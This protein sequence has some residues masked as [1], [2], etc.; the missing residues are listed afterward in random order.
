M[1]TVQNTYSINITQDELA[2][3]LSNFIIFLKK[4][5]ITFEDNDLEF[6]VPMAVEYLH[7]AFGLDGNPFQLVIKVA[8]RLEKEYDVA[9]RH[10]DG[11]WDK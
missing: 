2:T 6:D 10:G 3:L 1:H 4:D 5:E 8:D 9:C 11:D 7:K